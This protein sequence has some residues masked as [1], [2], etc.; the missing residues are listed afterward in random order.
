ME[1]ASDRGTDLIVTEGLGNRSIRSKTRR[2]FESTAIWIG[3]W[4]GHQ[5]LARRKWE[6]QYASH[7]SARACRSGSGVVKRQVLRFFGQRMHAIDRRRDASL[8]EMPETLEARVLVIESSR[9]QQSVG[10]HRGRASRGAAR[11]AVEG[12]SSSSR[13]VEPLTWGD[14]TIAQKWAATGPSQDAQVSEAW[15]ET[16][17][18]GGVRTKRCTGVTPNCHR[19]RVK[20]GLVRY[21]KISGLTSWN[22]R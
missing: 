13:V 11:L 12:R 9:K 5:R 21:R 7:E 4:Q 16:P 10:M 22:A 17:L 1:G 15:A 6:E 2:S 19:G 8:E 3:A 18:Q 14:M 20:S